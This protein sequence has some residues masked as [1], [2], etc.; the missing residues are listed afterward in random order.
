MI[1]GPFKS[2]SC[3]IIIS[4]NILQEKL[5]AYDFSLDTLDL[6][7]CHLKNRK[8]RVKINNK[9]RATKTVITGI[10]QIS[11]DRPFHPIFS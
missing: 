8:Q 2:L 6:M 10:L 9:F 11:I 1:Y 7:H 5:H 3:N 4:Y